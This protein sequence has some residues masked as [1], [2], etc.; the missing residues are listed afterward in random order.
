MWDAKKHFSVSSLIILLL[1]LAGQV[2][3]HV[4]EKA[5]VL[6]LPTDVYIKSGAIAVALTI[7]ALAFVPH[8]LFEHWTR[9]YTVLSLPALDRHQVLSLLSTIVL[10][11]AVLLG[12]IGSRDPLANPLPLLIWTVW[13]ISL[14]IIQGV[15]GDIWRSINPWSGFHQLLG[16]RT[17]VTLPKSLKYWPAIPIFAAFALFQVADIAPADPDRLAVFV[18]GYWLFTMAMT[19]TFGGEWLRRCEPFSIYFTQLSKLSTFWRNG[20]EIRAAFPGSRL[21]NAKC[22]TSLALLILMAL[23][24]GSFDGLNETFWW[25]AKIGINPLEFPGR[26]AVALEN[27]LGV[28]G[29]MLALGL[30][31]SSFLWVGLKLAN[32]QSQFA[33]LFPRFALS[34]IPIAMGYHLAH[35]LTS[36]LVD[37]QYA[38]KS[39][40]DPFGTGADY[41]DLGH[42]YVTTSFFNVPAMVKLIW[43]TQAGAIVLG[44]VLAVLIAHGIALQALGTQRRAILSQIP[45]GTFMVIY[46]FFGLWI[47]AQP[48]GT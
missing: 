35:Y 32:A 41:L 46:T 17:F 13:W 34:L 45:I 4:S 43:L 30:V 22:E 40:S 24:A 16:G 23:A 20:G 48:T 36:F 10:I 25:L 7:L 12:V 5:L 15:F 38:I 26:S 19:L 39:L 21:F 27:S 47:L 11:S 3:A 6:L 44:H 29:G 18:G 28:I 8:R 2:A 31:F 1:F 42:H 9:S 37:S 14:P 33:S